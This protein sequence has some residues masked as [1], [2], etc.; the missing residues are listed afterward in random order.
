MPHPET[1]WGRVM[2]EEHFLLAQPHCLS[3]HSSGGSRAPRALQCL[4]PGP[5]WAL[6]SS[7]QLWGSVL[8]AAGNT[9]SVLG[10]RLSPPAPPTSACALEPSLELVI[11]HHNTSL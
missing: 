9:P 10:L 7:T 11:S 1:W 8:I 5:T 2:A 4:A 6:G 3:C